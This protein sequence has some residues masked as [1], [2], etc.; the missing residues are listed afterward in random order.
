MAENV[1]QL[2]GVSKYY[3]TDT[4]VTQALRKI[5]LEFSMGEFVAITGESG[6]GKSTLLNIISGLDTFDEGEM[7]FRGQPTFP[8]D[9]ADWEEYRRNQIGFVFQDYSLINHY[10]ALDNII[11]AL[12]IQELEEE[13]AKEL[14][15]EYLSKVGLKDYAKQKASQLSSGQKQRLS[16]A[17]ALAKQTDIIV[18]DEP[19]GN[20]D[21]ETGEQIVRLLEELSK[22]RLVIMVTHN[23]EQVQKYV[24]RKIRLHDGEV[25]NDVSV[26]EKTLEK[27]NKKSDA[28]ETTG[29]KAKNKSHSLAPFLAKKNIVSQKGRTALIF[30]IFLITAV[31]SFLFIG[32]MLF[33]ADDRVA[34]EYDSKAYLQQNDCRLVVRYP[35]DR[36]L[37][38]EDQKK[39][40]A[41]KHVEEIDLYGFCNDVN[42]F[43]REGTE[44][45]RYFDEKE[46]F[47]E[48]VETAE[49]FQEQ[50]VLNEVEGVI[51]KDKTNFMK[52]SSC[53]SKDDLAKGRLPQSRNEIVIYS[54]DEDVLNTKSTCYFTANNI[55]SDEEMYHAIVEVVGILKEKTDQVYFDYRM[56][57]MLTTALDGKNYSMDYYWHPTDKEFKGKLKFEPVISDD[58]NGNEVRVSGNYKVPSTGYGDMPIEL[59][60]AFQNAAGNGMGLFHIGERKGVEEDAKAAKE[61]EYG[62][63]DER[64]DSS[65]VIEIERNVFI[66]PK[67]GE[68][69]LMVDIVP[70]FSE[71]GA[72]FLE[73]SE[74]MYQ[75]LYDRKTTQAGVYISNYSQTDKV[76]SEIAEMGYDVISTY[77]VSTTEYVPEK[78]LLRLQVLG[79]SFLVLLLLLFLQTLIVRSFM[80]IKMKDYNILK[81]MGM[82]FREMKRIS[83]F[84]LG[85]H[86]IFAIITTFFVMIVLN[87]F[88]LPFIT[89][90]MP[91]YKTAGIWYYV[92]YNVGVM[93]VTVAF[94]NR[95][96]KKKIQ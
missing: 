79:I 73:V 85:I 15:M 63:T 36:P 86:C 11:A 22:E 60:A 13:R 19:T 71:Q 23:Y 95:L 62:S 83:Y 38:G 74:E 46:E 94:F 55:W 32:E 6:G 90:I 59:D 33:Y 68:E 16:I 4:N 39:I 48:E 10:S 82:Q 49:G 87:L 70:G 21:S 37:T 44:Y 56:C 20:L 76:I 45:E 47:V 53:L 9:A 34:K 89:T 66:Y 84:E 52:S 91:C 18:A 64:W 41:V 24:T 54:E 42:Y 75:R 31:I 14:A 80:K 35:D 30:S 12:M 67:I 27:D 96:L 61:I 51:L 77:Q 93:I 78:V 57:Q 25:V 3:Y 40:A 69:I 5:N 7:F 58:L 92:M 81:F 17:R 65:K 50:I 72:G 43:Y 88:R 28:K 2:Q 29:K 8:F 1:L 26:N